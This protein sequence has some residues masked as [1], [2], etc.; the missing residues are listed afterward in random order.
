[1]SV[2]DSALYPVYIR[3]LCDVLILLCASI[4]ER[5]IQFYITP[6]YPRYTAIYVRTQLV[7]TILNPN[8][9]RVPTQHT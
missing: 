8:G 4:H 6:S 1:M 7:R 3:I 2:E 9:N 5:V